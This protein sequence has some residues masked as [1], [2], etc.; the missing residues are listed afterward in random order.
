MIRAHDSDAHSSEDPLV[1]IF[2]KRLSAPSY[3]VGQNFQKLLIGRENIAQLGV[4]FR[5]VCSENFR[6]PSCGEMI[7]SQSCSMFGGLE[8]A[9]N[10][11]C[12]NSVCE[13]NSGYNG[14]SCQLNIDDCGAVNCSGQGSCLDGTNNYTCICESGF[15]GQNCEVKLMQD[16]CANVECTEGT[17]CEAKTVDEQSPSAECVCN[18]NVS[19]CNT[20]PP[21]TTIPTD[22]DNPG[23]NLN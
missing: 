5:V 13:C 16:V 22:P 7:Q 9:G 10:G 6:G 12:V 1:D 8:C 11:V 2:V 14:D 17:H 15:S 3:Q 21:T 20:E 19:T 23:R 4:T 18:S